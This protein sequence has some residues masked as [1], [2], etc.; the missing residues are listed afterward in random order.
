MRDLPGARLLQVWSMVDVYLSR[1]ERKSQFELRS[2]SQLVG[3]LVS[4]DERRW[5]ASFDYLVVRRGS[6]GCPVW[7][8]ISGRWEQQCLPEV[9]DVRDSGC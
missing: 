2:V 6:T 3:S 7:V 4:W 8:G 9:V 5:A 1:T